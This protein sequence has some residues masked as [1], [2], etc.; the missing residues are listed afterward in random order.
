MSAKHF[1]LGDVLSITTMRML[2]PRGMDGVYDILRF[3]TG[4]DVATHQCGRVARECAPFLLKQHPQ[5]T[6]VQVPAITREN[7]A[8]VLEGLCAEYGD[9]VMVTQLPE[10]AHEIIDPHSE[11]AEKVHPKKITIIN[12]ADCI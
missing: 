7:F 2:S 11:M 3:M 5:L 9:E 8:S 10:N 4:N 12:Y 1:H 6:I